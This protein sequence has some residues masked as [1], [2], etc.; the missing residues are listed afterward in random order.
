MSQF[1]VTNNLAVPNK[2]N[3][4]RSSCYILNFVLTFL[5]YTMQLF[6]SYSFDLVLAKPICMQVNDVSFSQT[7]E[8]GFEKM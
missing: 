5:Q 8:R 1:D 7:E 6:L 3:G 2:I 4:M